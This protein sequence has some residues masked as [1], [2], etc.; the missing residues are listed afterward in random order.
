MANAKIVNQVIGAIHNPNQWPTIIN[1]LEGC[2]YYAY[3]FHDCDIDD[4][5]HEKN[6]S[7]FISLQKTG[8]ASDDGRPYLTF[9]KIWLRFLRF[10]LDLVIGTL[11]TLMILQNINIQ[12]LWF[13]QIAPFVLTLILLITQKSRLLN[14]FET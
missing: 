7:I 13:T 6:L 4:D 8:I 9:L 11:S 14:F 3:I 1:Q 5:T 12:N 2:K 10:L